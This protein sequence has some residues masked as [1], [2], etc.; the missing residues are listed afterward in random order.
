M[1]IHMKIGIRG[2]DLIQGSTDVESLAAAMNRYGIDTLQ[3]VCHKSVNGVTNTPGVLN[4]DKA[5]EISAA[6]R[7]KSIDVTLLGA[8]FNPVH[9]DAAKAE[10]GIAVFNDTFSLARSLGGGTV[11]S[12]TGS[13]NGD[14]WTY[15]PGNRTPEAIK[16]VTA[17]FAMLCE[18][19]AGIGSG[20]NVGIEGAAGHV[21]Y[22]AEVL[23]QVVN[24]TGCGNLRVIF[25]YF[26]FCDADNRDYLRILDDGLRLFSKIHCFHIKDC[27]LNG[28]LKGTA[29]GRGDMDIRRIV[30]MIQQYDA[31]A[32]RI[33]EGTAGEDIP[34]A[35]SL[36]REAWDAA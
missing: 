26:N 5:N 32:T 3:L 4:S 17:V 2:H 7:D 9:P 15:H 14:S 8:Y 12:E 33:L 19:A 34:R 27:K 18:A 21:C 35:V 36:L 29:L 22:N 10:S 6:L 25:D 28:P 11:G 1:V 23:R 16:T 13:L 20:V 24:D 31:N 30:K